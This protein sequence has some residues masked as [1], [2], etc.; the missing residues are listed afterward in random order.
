MRSPSTDRC[1]NSS[2]GRS[3]PPPC[4]R[5]PSCT[6]S[7]RSR[8]HRG[9]HGA[10]PRVRA[11]R[12]AAPTMTPVVPPLAL[13]D[14]ICEALWEH[15]RAQ[16]LAE[17]CVYLGLS[18]QAEHENPFNSKRSYVRQRLLTKTMDE[19]TDLARRVIAQ[20]GAPELA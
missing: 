9:Y 12:C 4:S 16:D 11:A 18:P 19:L 1:A 13:R 15:V 2:L 8:R 14:A 6:R 5:I 17:V 10:G 3:A 20:F 7:T